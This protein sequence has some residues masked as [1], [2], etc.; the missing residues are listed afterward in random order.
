[1]VEGAHSQSNLGLGH[2]NNVDASN[3]FPG[4]QSMMCSPCEVAPVD[5]RVPF[6][7]FCKTYDHW[8]FQCDMGVVD[9]SVD[10]LDDDG[11]F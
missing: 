3:D 1:M 4:I 10:V 7:R 5:E 2:S 6:C 8:Y 9:A 11:S